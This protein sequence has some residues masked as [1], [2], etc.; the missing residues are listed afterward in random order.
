MAYIGQPPFQEFSSVPTKDSFTGDGSTT[1]FDLA[2]DVVRGAEN[3][4]EVFV[5][6]VRQEPGTGK[7]FTL[8]V[9][10]SN[11]FRR[12]TFTA[13]PA[14]GASIYVINDKTNLTAIAPVN[15]DF[16]GAELVLD[17]DADTTLH[18]D[19]DDEIDVQV[20]GNDIITIKQSSG[21][22][23][24]TIPVDA[25]DLQFTQFDG[26][27]VLEINDAGFV[28]VGGNSNAAGE[29]RIFEDTDNGSNYVGLSAPNVTTSRTYI[30]PAA[31][32][33]SGT[34]LTTDGSGNLSWSASLQLANDSN[35]RVVTGTGSGLNGEANLTF[36]GSTLALTG[37]M[38]VSTNNTISFRDSGLTI[39]SNADGD[40]DIVSDGTAVDSI[41][42]ESAGGI[43]L[44]AGTAGSGIIYEDDGTEMMRIHNSSS[45]V[46]LESKVSDK[47]IIFKV[48]DGGSST[49]VFR[50]D[51]DVS[52]LLVASGK[53]LRFADSGEKISGNGTDLTLNSGAD[54]NLTA[55]T[56]INIP[57][58]VGLTFGDDAEK[59]EG[60]GTDLTISGNNINLTAT[61]DV[62]VP[63]NV[64]ITFGS[65][66]KIE[67]DDTD[68]TIT[69]GAKIN[70]TATS[71]IHVPN[72]VGIVFGGDSEKIE[73]DGTDMTISANNLTIDAAA[74]ITLDA[75]GNDLNFA[76]GGTTV[77]TI[78]NSSSDVVIKPVV[79]AKD[80]IFQQRD[81]TE[82]MRIE[83]GAHVA[84]TAAALNPE[85]TL[86]DASTISWN[87][88]TSPVAK[89]T[90]GANRTLGAGSGAIAGQFVSLLVIQDGTG[91]RT[92]S[93]NAAYEFKDDT[94]PTLTTTAA[95]GDL[96][97]FRYNG[98]KFLEVGRNQNLTL[99]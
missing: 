51:G 67:G 14:N 11:N 3:A 60:D 59:I 56:D 22:G 95:K 96:F 52:A 13:A 21:D 97:V 38:T 72:N 79:D 8:G 77:L 17:A 43:T 25:K 41:N 49:E 83:D 70:L 39:G 99:S 34:H 55:T 20:A 80:L 81:G 58:N 82:V 94:A 15:T 57:A 27:K 32:G 84:F 75:A 69:S 92:L 4:L 47:D 18:A 63:A 54:I 31:D 71:D 91:S 6:N 9:D 19:T 74:D 62:V 85:A 42:I 2:N 61:A 29:I 23:I 35:N 16:N 73:G 66:E 36:D 46:I 68:L 24:I 64:G 50:V 76:A 53:E 26:H 40:L 88:L 30:F 98:S 78:S 12:I 7:A 65:G 87:V 89:V 44:D 33:S 90:L 37:A 10:G 5:D 1:T 28:G 48:N 93:F 86:T 45:D